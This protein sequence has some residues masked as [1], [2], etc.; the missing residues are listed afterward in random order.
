MALI[1]AGAVMTGLT[2]GSY[3]VLAAIGQQCPKRVQ[4][5]QDFD[6]SQYVGRWFEFRRQKELW[7]ESGTCCYVQYDP[8]GQKQIDVHNSEY[9]DKK[10]WRTVQANGQVSQWDSGFVGVQFFFLQPFA[11]YRVV[12]TDY[13]TYAIVYSCDHLVAEAFSSEA[14]W[15]LTREPLEIDSDEH[16]AMD[17]MT[18]KII[19]ERIPS[20]DFGTSMFTP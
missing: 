7:F 20:Y 5:Q 15:V 3:Y 14:L 16:K 8:L 18:K 2:W 6:R 4:L 9:D 10:G 19:I 12:S 1:T 11:D 13:K 17:A